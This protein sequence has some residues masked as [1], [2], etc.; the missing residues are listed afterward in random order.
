MVF[1]YDQIQREDLLMRL[2]YVLKN[3]KLKEFKSQV[4]TFYIESSDLVDSSLAYLIT[5]HIPGCIQ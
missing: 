3:P 1:R 4:H 2:A 5:Y